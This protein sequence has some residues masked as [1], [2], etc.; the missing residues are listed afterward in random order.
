MIIN[1]Y[2]LSTIGF[3]YDANLYHC[4]DYLISGTVGVGVAERDAPH[5]FQ[6]LFSTS[7]LKQNINFFLIFFIF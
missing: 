7:P 2:Y 6:N 5:C 1:N 4:N 3:D